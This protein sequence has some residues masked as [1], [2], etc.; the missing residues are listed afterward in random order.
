ML[1]RPYRP[2]G[3]PD[4]HRLETRYG[5]IEPARAP[6]YARYTKAHLTRAST[7]LARRLLAS[8]SFAVWFCRY[9]GDIDRPRSYTE[10]GLE[11]GFSN[12]SARNHT[13]AAMRIIQANTWVPPIPDDYRSDV[14]LLYCPPPMAEWR[15]RD[16]TLRP[17][18]SYLAYRR[19]APIDN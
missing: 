7:P 6:W 9:G 13:R 16:G 4:T 5:Y 12:T 3:V 11:F 18:R 19:P 2:S 1:R 10:A 14:K 17:A 15:S 8:R